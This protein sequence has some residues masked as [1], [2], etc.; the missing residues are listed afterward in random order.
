MATCIPSI[1]L[2]QN[3]ISG[4]PNWISGT[5][6]GLDDQR[7]CGSVQRAFGHGTARDVA[8]H[9]I[10]A[11]GISDPVTAATRNFI[12]LSFRVQ[13]A[14]ALIDQADTV[15]LGLATASGANAILIKLKAHAS[16]PPGAGKPWTPGTLP[17]TLASTPTVWNW[18]GTQWDSLATPPAWIAT[19]A[20][21]WVHPNTDAADANNRW[22]IQVG[23]PRGGASITD[24]NAPNLGNDFKLWYMVQGATSVGAY[25]V[26]ADSMAG[27]A[28]PTTTGQLEITGPHPR[29]TVTPPTNWPDFHLSSGPLDPVC[30]VSTTGGG[31]ALRQ[32]DIIVDNADGLIHNH[33]NNTFLVRPRNYTSNAIAP[34]DISATFRIANWGTSVT[35][36]FDA[37]P[38]WGSAT[39]TYLPG[40][41]AINP[42]ANAVNI[43]NIVAGANPT[44][45]TGQIGL[46]AM[47]NRTGQQTRHQCILVTLTGTGLAAGS[48]LFFL[49]DSAFR[50]MWYDVASLIEREAE[51]SVVGLTPFSPQPRDVYLSVE[52]I[53]MQRTLPPGTNE[54]QFL[55]AT[56]ERLMA[57]GGELAEKLKIARDRL[58]QAGDFGSG[59]E[60]ERLLGAL[61]EAFA[62]LPMRVETE[63]LRQLIDALGK[64]LMSV[65]QSDEAARRLAE[66]FDALAG[67]LNSSGSDAIGKL[68]ALMV[69]L[70]RWLSS[71]DNDPA[72]LEY[73]PI[74]A[75]SLYAWVSN[76]EGAERLASII[77]NLMGWLYNQRPSDQLSAILNPLRELLA[78]VG[79]EGGRW[80]APLG[81]FAEQGAGWL[82]GHE[83]IGAFVNAIAEAGLSDEQIDQLFPTFRVHAYHDTG[84]R[85]T[86]SD[87]VERPVLSIQSSFGLYAYHEGD[88]EGWQTSIE[89]ARRIDEN[90]YLLAVPNESTAR[91]KVRIQ[92]VERGQERIAE[93]PIKPFDSIK[94]GS[95]RIDTQPGE[96]C[97]MGLLRI[98]FRLIGRLISGS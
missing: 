7:W 30:P 11:N 5:D 87:G 64:W 24:T 84:A 95:P 61:Y 16:S 49:N 72:S 26:L 40:N 15:Y 58:A 8:F 85:V 67:W 57:Q 31:V 66:V 78:S 27:T 60:L 45:A 92:A 54:G 88:L 14:Q 41:S 20:R 73:M 80:R 35:G 3:A 91:V 38:N 28:F 93:D 63:A 90:L 86:G 83:R 69:Q 6:N 76:L 42:V 75:E 55:A 33:Q 32:A 68:P 12:Y 2:G 70:T 23:V 46:T 29:P 52:K 79:D 65:K 62:A 97:L 71:L 18:S 59:Q 74:V 82:R 1:I 10:Y 51:I 21:V 39:W 47:M 4:P 13:F 48:S 43:T 94:W 77:E 44:A 53:N 34:G 50:N 98:V 56:T 17:V 9:A 36:N 22:A 37:T 19:Y 96:G 89:G 25:V 81:A